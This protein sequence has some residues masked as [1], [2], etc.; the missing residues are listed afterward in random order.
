MIK[1]VSTPTV[2]PS[3]WDNPRCS[4]KKDWFIFYYLYTDKGRTKK[5]VKGMNHLKTWQ[6]RYKA[7]KELLDAEIARL[8]MPG[9][10]ENTFRKAPVAKLQNCKLSEALLDMVERK[11][12]YCVPRHCNNLETKVKRFV[13]V[14]TT[15]R[16]NLAIQD[17]T[18]Q[19]CLLVLS[20][21]P[22]HFPKYTDTTYNSYVKDIGALFSELHYWEYIDSS[23]FEKIK[24]RS[25]VKELKTVATAA[26]RKLIDK[27]LFE[28]NYALWRFM[29]IFFHSGAREAELC[30]MKTTDIHLKDRFFVVTIKKG[31][32]RRQ[33][34]KAILPAA[35]RHWAE[36]VA[37]GEKY[38][39]GKDL[40]PGDT[41]MD[42]TKICVLWRRLVKKELG[43]I[44]VDFYSL[45]HLHTDMLAETEGIETAQAMDDHLNKETTMIYAVGEKKRKLNKLKQSQLKF[46]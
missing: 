20:E 35:Y 9:G 17:I 16:L 10:V 6:E 1:K 30:R 2:S 13:Q 39:F 7:T 38:P 14:A 33:E 3:N 37:E 26:Q 45:K 42:P 5:V 31:K 43:Y 25:V 23:P 4:L 36:V 27:L 46:V 32:S 34:V 11:R 40:L 19:H 24:K 44:N 18:R 15:L 21:M 28:K 41:P 8:K 12:E 29:H 22:K